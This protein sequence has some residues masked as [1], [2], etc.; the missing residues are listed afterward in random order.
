MTIEERAMEDKEENGTP[1][2]APGRLHRVLKTIDDKRRARV[3]H[4]KAKTGRADL[5]MEERKLTQQ[6]AAAY[7]GVSPSTIHRWAKN[8]LKITP[9]G[10]RDRFLVKDLQEYMKK[11]LR[12]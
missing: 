10:K 11:W 1:A 4:V 8:G 9:Y 5:P 6:E 2:T 12:R 7:C 3:E